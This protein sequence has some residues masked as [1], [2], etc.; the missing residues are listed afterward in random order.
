MSILN[1]Q[2]KVQQAFQL[3]PILITSKRRL[4]A[5]KKVNQFQDFHKN[6]RNKKCKTWENHSYS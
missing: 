5:L 4:S 2:E 3:D 1:L 6:L